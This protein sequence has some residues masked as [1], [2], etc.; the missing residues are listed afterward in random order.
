M[1]SERTARMGSFSIAIKSLV[2]YSLF[3]CILVTGLLEKYILTFK[4]FFDI[5]G[6]G[7]LIFT[8]WALLNYVVLISVVSKNSVLAQYAILCDN[9]VK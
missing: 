9:K 4:I 1:W 3:K 2:Y 6:F 8:P 5:D 7:T